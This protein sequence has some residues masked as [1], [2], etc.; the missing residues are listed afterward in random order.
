[1][2]NSNPWS[3]FITQSIMLGISA[4]IGGTQPAIIAERVPTRYR[5]RI[6]GTSMPLAVAL[7]GGTAPYLN[8]WFFSNDMSWAMYVYIGVVC[9]IST[10]VVWNWKETKGIHLSEID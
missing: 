5:A 1:M 8:S 4:C 9:T 10:I 2:I 7:F 3:L 6:M